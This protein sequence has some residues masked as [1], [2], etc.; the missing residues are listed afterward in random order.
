VK[1][2]ELSC[3]IRRLAEMARSQSWL[4]MPTWLRWTL[5]L[6]VKFPAI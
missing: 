6:L 5:S 2:N 3:D 1:L 4:L